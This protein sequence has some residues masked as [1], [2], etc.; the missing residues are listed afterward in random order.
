MKQN[1]FS[2]AVIIILLGSVIF[3][4]EDTS[5]TTDNP[6][7]KKWKWESSKSRD[8]DFFNYDFD[9]DLDFD[10]ISINRKPAIS[11]SFGST[12][13]K[14][15]D[16]QTKNL[17]D[18]LGFELKLG[19]VKQKNIYEKEDLIKEH[20]NYFLLINYS[21]YLKNKNS[22]VSDVNSD[23]WKFGFGNQ[24]GYG[25]KLSESFAIIPYT[26]SSLNWSRVN[27]AYDTNYVNNND[28]R[29]MRMYDESFRFG[30]SSAG[31]IKVQM[32]DNLAVDFSYERQ[33]VFQRVLFWKWAGSSIIELASQGLL[34]NFIDKIFDS[35]PY[36][37]PIVSF[38]LKNAL[39]YGIYELRQEKMNWPFRSESPLSFDQFKVGVIFIF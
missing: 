7:E 14:R 22:K 27:F 19:T 30:N 18:P 39:S 23:T 26:E 5:K 28:I 21:S 4:Q 2:I 10:F 1:V 34:D 12:Q 9:Y 38:V 11:L 24:K 8:K 29:I 31:G 37:A 16:I 25:Y 17:V 32:F 6:K 20:Y 13:L 33:I 35:S 36:A 15:K 3:S